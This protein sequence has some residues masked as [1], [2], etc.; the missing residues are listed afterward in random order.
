MLVRFS[1]IYFQRIREWLRQVSCCQSQIHWKAASI[2]GSKPF[3]FFIPM[4]VIP[5]GKINLYTRA[6]LKHLSWK[7]HP[8]SLTPRKWLKASNYSWKMLLWPKNVEFHKRW[9]TPSWGISMC[10]ILFILSS[11]LLI[12]ASISTTVD[13]EEQKDCI[14]LIIFIA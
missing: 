9:R 11:R 1:H 10:T 13:P 4:E 6:P 5:L 7:I 14:T 3:F 8:I 2:V 12:S